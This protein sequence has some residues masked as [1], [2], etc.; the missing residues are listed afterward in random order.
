MSFDVPPVTAYMH[1]PSLWVV[2]DFDGDNPIHMAGYGLDPATGDDIVVAQAINENISVWVCRDGFVAF[3]YS[4]RSEIGWTGNPIEMR[5]ARISVAN[6][7]IACLH[8]ALA[9][10][11]NYPAESDLVTHYT[12]MHGRGDGL[13]ASDPLRRALV[14][15]GPKRSLNPMI[16]GG[17]PVTKVTWVP[18]RHTMSPLAVQTSVDWLAAIA[19]GGLERLRRYELLLQAGIA[20]QESNYSLATITSW[21]LA[22]QA[23]RRIWANVVRELARDTSSI[24]AHDAFDRLNA[25]YLLSLLRMC[26]AVPEPLYLDLKKTKKVRND[27]EH[28]LRAPSREEAVTA[29]MS[30][31]LVMAAADGLPF[32]VHP[33]GSDS[34]GGGF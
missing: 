20:F 15:L 8:A 7:H 28:N 14:E 32:V 1:V 30:A 22:E 10:L 5:A 11:D 3:L 19:A 18:H 24:S 16:L 9:Q 17:L 12:A 2:D 29:Q 13:S 34:G 31:A 23:M 33:T 25:E 4:E 6:A 26:G 27:W 21:A